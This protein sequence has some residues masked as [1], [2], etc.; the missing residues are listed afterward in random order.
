MARFVS[1]EGDTVS[2]I[3]QET[4]MPNFSQLLRGNEPDF[5]VLLKDES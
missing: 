3:E 5:G 1:V 2:V 4:R